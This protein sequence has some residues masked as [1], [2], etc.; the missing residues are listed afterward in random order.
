MVHSNNVHEPDIRL[1][2]ST[3]YVHFNYTLYVFQP[4]FKRIIRVWH[5]YNVYDYLIVVGTCMIPV[6]VPGWLHGWSLSYVVCPL[7]Y[8]VL[9]KVIVNAIWQTFHNRTFKFVCAPDSRRFPTSLCIWRVYIILTTKW[10]L[11]RLFVCVSRG[12][13]AAAELLNPPSSGH[14]CGQVKSGSC[15]GE[16]SFLW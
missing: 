14:L 11:R 13:A 3:S 2:L 4:V 5:R 8:Y 12:R 6:C 15:T 7:H 10:A 9:V 1:W 16:T